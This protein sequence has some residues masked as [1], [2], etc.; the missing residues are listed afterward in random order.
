MYANDEVIVREECYEEDVTKCKKV[1][2]SFVMFAIIACINHGLFICKYSEKKYLYT[3]TSTYVLFR[4]YQDK[5]DVIP[6]SRKGLAFE[7]N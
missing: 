6:T 3:N 5:P 2:I 7:T 1:F 4:F